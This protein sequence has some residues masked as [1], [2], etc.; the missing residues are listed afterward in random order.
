MQLSGLG[1]TNIAADIGLETNCLP[2]FYFGIVSTIINSSIAGWSPLIAGYSCVLGA[3]NSKH[4]EFHK[5]RN[6][7][8]V[9]WMRGW[10]WSDGPLILARLNVRQTVAPLSI[11]VVITTLSTLSRKWNCSGQSQLWMPTCYYGCF[12]ISP[13]CR[14]YSGMLRSCVA[15]WVVKWSYRLLYVLLLV[16]RQ[17]ITLLTS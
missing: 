6:F 17:T 7:W 13:H 11:V 16:F 12:P 4:S 1:T 15:S 14:L 5:A 3:V 2:L 10:V 9:I 8:G